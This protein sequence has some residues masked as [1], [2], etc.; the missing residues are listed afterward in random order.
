[1]KTIT[2]LKPAKA[3][4]VTPDELAAFAEKL[5]DTTDWRKPLAEALYV[6]VKTVYRWEQEESSIPGPVFAWMQ[7]MKRKHPLQKRKAKSP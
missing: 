6:D 2:P 4:L 3:M 1:M 5:F 7:S